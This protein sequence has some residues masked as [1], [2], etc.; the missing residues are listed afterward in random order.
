MSL[1]FHN[2]LTRNVDEF[3]PIE[4][5]FIRLYTCGPT[6]YNY[7][8]VGNW[9]SYIYWDSLVRVLQT[10]TKLLGL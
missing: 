2:Q 4:E 10:A 1:R 8:T 9:V 5:G 3:K 6:V 7:P